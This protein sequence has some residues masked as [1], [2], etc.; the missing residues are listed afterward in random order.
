MHALRECTTPVLK[1][2]TQETAV[3][4]YSRSL[5]IGVPSS[6][7]QAQKREFEI[8]GSNDCDPME[9]VRSSEKRYSLW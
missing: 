3:M 7:A 4:T 6:G 1:V 2:I 9:V 8:V 5:N